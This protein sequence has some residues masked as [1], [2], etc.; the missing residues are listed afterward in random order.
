DAAP[1]SGRVQVFDQYS[2]S[3]RPARLQSS[4][5]LQGR[6]ADP[7]LTGRENIAFYGDL[8][9]QWTD[10]W[11]ELVERFN[12]AAELDRPVAEYS[13]GMVRKLELAIALTPD[14]PLYLLDEPTAALDLS[15]MTTVRSVLADIRAAGRTVVLAS[16]APQDAELADRIAFVA[17]GTIVA[18]GTPESLRAS[19]P[20]VVRAVSGTHMSAVLPEE[21]VF[22]DGAEQRGFLTMKSDEQFSDR[23]TIQSETS[24]EIVEPSYTD[25][26]NYYAHVVRQDESDFTGH[27]AVR[28]QSPE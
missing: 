8:H 1:D 13:G 16:H 21:R 14:V 3:D 4:V 20:P 15:I 18:E 7:G 12:L 19:V 10:R 26:F 23:K 9:P 2:P 17:R 28:R 25:V 24:L 5:L 22:T 11:Q 27:G 6:T